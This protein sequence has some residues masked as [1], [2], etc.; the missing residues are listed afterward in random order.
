M[1]RNA[2]S[3]LKYTEFLAFEEEYILVPWVHSE[4]SPWE[5]LVV[6][7]VESGEREGEL[8]TMIIFKFHHCLADGQAILTALMQC[9]D[10]E[11]QGIES[12]SVIQW[13]AVLTLLRAWVVGAL[14]SPYAISTAII[15]FIHSQFKEHD[16]EVE[17]SWENLKISTEAGRLHSILRCGIPTEGLKGFCNAKGA[18][19]SAVLGA[20][21]AGGIRNFLVQTQPALPTALDMAVF[22][23]FPFRGDH[24]TNAM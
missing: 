17:N 7:N 22:L 21:I 8:C 12:G 11:N 18:K 14:S 15:S 4:R 3:G 16:V 23:P 20:G 24:L 6:E 1:K 19:F 9:T 10:D 13:R 5:C 2:E